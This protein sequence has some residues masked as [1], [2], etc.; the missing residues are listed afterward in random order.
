MQGGSCLKQCSL[1]KD[2]RSSRGAVWLICSLSV[3]VSGQERHHAPGL[4]PVHP[5]STVFNINNSPKFSI[6]VAVMLFHNVY[7]NSLSNKPL[8]FLLPSPQFFG[9]LLHQ[10][11]EQQTS[12]RRA[13]HVTTRQPQVLLPSSPLHHQDVLTQPPPQALTQHPH[14]HRGQGPGPGRA[15]LLSQRLCKHALHH[16]ALQQDQPGHQ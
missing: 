11:P 12:V 8:F 6:F 1:N 13:S 3:S 5:I 9:A 10:Q 4:L 2:V 7:P 14:H 16:V 15:Q